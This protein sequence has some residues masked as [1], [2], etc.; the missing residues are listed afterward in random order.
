[1]LLENY[2]DRKLKEL[3]QALTRSDFNGNVEDEYVVSLLYV[4]MCI[5]PL[6]DHETIRE[7][8]YVDIAKEIIRVYDESSRQYEEV[9]L[10]IWT[11]SLMR[12][13]KEKKKTY[14]DIHRMS[15]IDLL[16]E[17]KPLSVSG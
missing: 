2:R 6:Q 14:R 1:M 16:N 17:L 3:Y 10:M 15:S 11:S 5:D 8:N 9:S 4:M 7:R 13:M 12:Y